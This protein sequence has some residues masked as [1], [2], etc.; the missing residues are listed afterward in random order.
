[1]LTDVTNPLLG[2]AGAA[3]VYGPQKGATA[4]EVAA[5]ETALGRLAALMP[6]AD[7]HAAGAGAAGGT[8]F[9]LTAWGARLRPGAAVVADL[10]GLPAA[11]AEASVVLTGEGAY[12]ASTAAGKAPALLAAIAA[13]AGVPAI[14]VAGRVDGR[15]AGFALAI[16]LTEV[17]GS[18]AAAMADPARWL[19]AAGRRA[20]AYHGEP[21]RPVGPADLQG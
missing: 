2:A 17:A 1:V 15:P 6:A 13:R 14:L 9:G 18:A 4:A 10:I 3:A 21:H 8:G 5:M 20:G 19:A 11:V 12:D 7:P 16:S